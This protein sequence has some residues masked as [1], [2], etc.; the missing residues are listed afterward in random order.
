MISSRTGKCCFALFTAVL[1]APSPSFGAEPERFSPACD[2]VRTDAVLAFWRDNADVKMAAIIRRVLASSNS[3]EVNLLVLGEVFSGRISVEQLG[4]SSRAGL[5]AVDK[6]PTC[7]DAD[8]KSSAQFRALLP[9]ILSALRQKV[10]E[11][12]GSK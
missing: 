11:M 10:V 12:R 5:D 2:K 6:S 3:S 8:R 4:N 1:A 9:Q 7:N